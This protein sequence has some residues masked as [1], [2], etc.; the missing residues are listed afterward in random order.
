MQRYQGG[1]QALQ[2]KVVFTCA[3]YV[4]NL[5]SSLGVPVFAD[6][7]LGVFTASFTG[8]LSCD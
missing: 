5:S 2:A 7:M 4:R 1:C 3:T 6:L 8:L